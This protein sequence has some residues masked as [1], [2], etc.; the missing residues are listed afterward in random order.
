MSMHFGNI[1][2]IYSSAL[3]L[4]QYYLS[5][6]L[7]SVVCPFPLPCHLLACHALSHM[8]RRFFNDI[9]FHIQFLQIKYC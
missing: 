5:L 9:V 8:I 2:Y 4:H 6:A 3:L 7:T 1:I